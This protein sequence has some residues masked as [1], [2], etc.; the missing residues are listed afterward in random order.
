MRDRTFL[1]LCTVAVAVL[2]GALAPQAG[3]QGPQNVPPK[4]AQGEP[5]PGSAEERTKLLEELYAR[6]ASAG[7]PEAAEGIALS[8]QR[9]WRFSGSA[10]ADL[11]L[12]RATSATQAGRYDLALK[13]LGTTL[14]LQPDFAD[15]WN[16]RAFVHYLKNNYQRALGDLRRALALEPNH[17]RALDGL[18][19]IL[20][21]LGEKK[22][23]LSAYKSLLAVYPYAPGAKEAVSEL[24]TE[25]EGQGI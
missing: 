10:T 18:A 20:R 15:A 8:I 21:E 17:F 3:A 2:V 24:T 23:A 16:E 13:L 12:E 6:L 14:E 1:P 4:Q 5:A 9:L 7:G 11:L 22:G 19:R 25:V